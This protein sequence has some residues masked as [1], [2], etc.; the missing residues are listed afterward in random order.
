MGSCLE[1]WGDCSGNWEVAG[2][3]ILAQQMAKMT[4][5]EVKDYI[6]NPT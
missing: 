5:C 4:P 2:R 1:T 6:A 3:V